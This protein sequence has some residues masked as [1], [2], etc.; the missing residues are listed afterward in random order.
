MIEELTQPESLKVLKIS[1]EIIL[2]SITAVAREPPQTEDLL[3]SLSSSTLD[4]I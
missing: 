3:E 4:K 1:I 2:V